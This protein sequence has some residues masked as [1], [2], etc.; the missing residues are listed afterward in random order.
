MAIP[1]LKDLACATKLSVN[2][3]TDD[4]PNRPASSG[5]TV[6]SKVC[7]RRALMRSATAATDSSNPTPITG[8]M[9]MC[10]PWPHDHQPTTA[11]CLEYR[12]TESQPIGPC[13]HPDQGASRYQ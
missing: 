9:K 8:T 7:F 12:A 1:A 13:R 11:I 2:S 4:R 3:S 6:P 5:P 10:C